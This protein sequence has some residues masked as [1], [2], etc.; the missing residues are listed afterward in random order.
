MRKVT[1]KGF[2][3]CAFLMLAMVGLRD[4]HCGADTWNYCDFFV[5][6]KKARHI[7]PYKGLSLDLG[8]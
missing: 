7:I 3:L 2:C 1:N 4:I 6:P 5:N 8:F